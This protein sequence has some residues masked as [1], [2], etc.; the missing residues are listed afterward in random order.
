MLHSLS[1]RGVDMDRY[2]EYFK[3]YYDQH[4]LISIV[5]KDFPYMIMGYNIFDDVYEKI[6]KTELQKWCDENFESDYCLWYDA[7]NTENQYDMILFK[8]TWL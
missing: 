3:Q 5:D 7:L 1:Y 6:A 4:N 8:L 2:E